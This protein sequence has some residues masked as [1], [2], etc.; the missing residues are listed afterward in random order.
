MPGVSRPGLS[1]GNQRRQGRDRARAHLTLGHDPEL[2]HVRGGSLPLLRSRRGR[3]PGRR[4]A[5]A[6][7]PGRGL[8]RELRGARRQ[9]D[10]GHPRP[11]RRQSSRAVHVRRDGQQRSSTDRPSRVPGACRAEASEAQKIISWYSARRSSGA[12]LIAATAISTAT[13]PSTRPVARDRSI[14]RFPAASRVTTAFAA[15]QVNS[16]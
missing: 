4:H 2:R 16:G 13:K 6:V 3:R 15:H 14:L 12:P 9:T 11:L 1:Q 10:E 7:G 5:G 8:R